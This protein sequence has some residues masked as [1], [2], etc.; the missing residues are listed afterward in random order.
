MELVKFKKRLISVRKPK[1]N[2]LQSL[3]L[4]NE[5]EIINLIPKNKKFD[6]TDLINKCLKLRKKIG[7]YEIPNSSWT[8]LGKL[9][10]FNKA[11][12]NFN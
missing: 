5:R 2:F 3:A 11:F 8:D 7:V 9:S 10:D 12:K 6:L 4:H 1:L